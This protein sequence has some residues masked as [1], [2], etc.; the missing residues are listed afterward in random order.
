MT[1]TTEAAEP[2]TATAPPPRMTLGTA[3]ILLA[4]RAAPTLLSAS[5]VRA[6]TGLPVGSVSTTLRRL[7]DLGLATMQLEQGGGDHPR[8]YRD[9][10]AGIGRRRKHY[11]ELTDEGRAAAEA[12]VS[13]FPTEVVGGDDQ[14]VDAAAAEAAVNAQL[15]DQLARH[16]LAEIAASSATYRGDELPAWARTWDDPDGPDAAFMRI[17]AQRI[18]AALYSRGY[19]AGAGEHA[20]R[21]RQLETKLTAARQELADMGEAYSRL[22]DQ[23]S[24]GA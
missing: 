6:Q 20:T 19:A 2:E 1:E 21:E 4:L 9:K 13:R 8:T 11:Y 15:A 3:R 10:A 18:G 24:R 5:E 14:V 7:L 16:V 23:R 22:A 12:A 17:T